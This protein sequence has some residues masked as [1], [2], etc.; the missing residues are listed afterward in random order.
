M[1]LAS[2]MFGHGH[3]DWWDEIE[4][5]DLVFLDITQHLEEVE[6]LHDIRWNLPRDGSDAVVC[7][8]I[9]MILEDVNRWHL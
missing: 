5:S 4:I 3:S 2:W 9:R 8:A 6:L 1:L 7:L